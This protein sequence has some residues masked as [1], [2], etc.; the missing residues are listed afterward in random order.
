M[1]KI[2]IPQYWVT[3]RSQL[4][5]LRFLMQVNNCSFANHS[6]RIPLMIFFTVF[7]IV[8]VCVHMGVHVCRYGFTCVQIYVYRG[9]RSTSGFIPEEPSIFCSFQS[10]PPAQNAPSARLGSQ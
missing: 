2:D 4:Y 3:L 1:K 10:L 6:I 5:K 8:F 9:Q 7:S